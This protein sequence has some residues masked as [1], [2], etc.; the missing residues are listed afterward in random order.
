MVLGRT[1]REYPIE[2]IRPSFGGDLDG[3]LDC[4]ARR[5][6]VVDATG[7]PSILGARLPKPRRFLIRGGLTVEGGVTANHAADL[8]SAEIIEALSSTLSTELEFFV[9]R[10]RTP[11]EDHQME[12]A[13]TA[14]SA[15]RDEGL[16][17]SIGL[18]LEGPAAMPLWQLNDAFDIAVVPSDGD[19]FVQA[20][21]LAVARRVGLVIDGKPRDGETTHIRT[22]ASAF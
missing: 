22:Y 15:A 17:R 13:L 2:W 6:D 1:N 8:M 14:L 7:M 20:I 16:I 9:L 19:L 12:G 10:V 4:L 11:L 21:K 5:H 18:G 3:L